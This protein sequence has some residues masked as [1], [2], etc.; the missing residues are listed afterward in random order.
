MLSG[1]SLGT[2]DL[3][4]PSR[5]CSTIRAIAR[6]SARTWGAASPAAIGSTGGGESSAT[7]HVNEDGTVVVATGSPDHGGRNLGIDY[8]RVRPIVADTASVGYTNLTAGSR[9]TFA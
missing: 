9:V 7:M 1:A 8:D 5:R 6:R 3:P 2:T 4:R